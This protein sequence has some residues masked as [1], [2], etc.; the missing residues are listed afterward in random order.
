MQWYYLGA[1]CHAT[2][3]YFAA[4]SLSALHPVGGACPQRTHCSRLPPRP[5]QPSL[6]MSRLW[7]SGPIRGVGPEPLAM[8]I[9][10]HAMGRA[11]DHAHCGGPY[12]RARKRRH[13][14][15]LDVHDYATDRVDGW[16]EFEW[17]AHPPLKVR[18]GLQAWAWQRASATVCCPRRGLRAWV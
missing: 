16:C 7:L 15:K 8:C 18:Q 17:K 6:H 5:T 4:R 12:R 9:G 2:P 10:A 1:L 13:G 11:M 3:R 14:A